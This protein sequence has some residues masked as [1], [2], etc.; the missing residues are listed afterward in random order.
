MSAPNGFAARG[1]GP[2]FFCDEL[3]NS[4]SD[5]NVIMGVMAIQ[6]IPVLVR[7]FRSKEPAP[8]W[9]IYLYCGF[10]FL[11]FALILA[12]LDC[13]NYFYTAFVLR[14]VALLTVLL[15]YPLALIVLWRTRK[16]PS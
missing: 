8:V 16:W 6:L 5:D 4:G 13:G 12:G 10:S 7:L 3:M 11:S 9:E 14:D 15:I 2:V 1:D